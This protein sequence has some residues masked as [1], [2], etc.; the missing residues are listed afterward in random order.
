MSK[1]VY[2]HGVSHFHY[3][4]RYWS[5]MEVRHTVNDRVGI[6]PRVIQEKFINEI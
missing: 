3:D 1:V 6:L 5:I 2:I 4:P